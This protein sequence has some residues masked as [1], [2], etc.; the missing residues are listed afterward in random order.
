MSDTEKVSYKMRW[1]NL[2]NGLAT[3]DQEIKLQLMNLVVGA[4]FYQ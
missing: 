3:F 4:I 1:K 2:Q